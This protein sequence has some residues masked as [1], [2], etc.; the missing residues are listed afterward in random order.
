MEPNKFIKIMRRKTKAELLL[1]IKD[2][3]TH[4]VE[5]MHFNYHTKSA[6]IEQL[7]AETYYTKPG[8]GKRA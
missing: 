5:K 4:K 1:L 2:E 3:Y 6:L 8:N 7:Y